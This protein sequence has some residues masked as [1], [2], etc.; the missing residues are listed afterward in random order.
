[1]FVHDGDE[2]IVV[3]AFDEVGKFVDDD[4]FDTFERLLGQ[5]QIQPDAF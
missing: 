3:V 5:L 1:M 2:A 4:V